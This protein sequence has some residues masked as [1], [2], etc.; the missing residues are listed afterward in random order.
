[1]IDRYEGDY[2]KELESKFHRPFKSKM[3][4]AKRGAVKKRVDEE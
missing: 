2:V 4:R 1:M 3:K